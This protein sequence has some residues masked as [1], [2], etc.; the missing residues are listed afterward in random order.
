MSPAEIVYR[1]RQGWRRW[2][3]RWKPVNAQLLVGTQ[4]TLPI[5]PGLLE[6]AKLTA[7]NE[8]LLVAMAL[9]P[10]Q[11][12][13]R[14]LGREWA[15]KTD[16][17][18]WHFDP[19]SEQVWPQA[20][21]CMDIDLRQNGDLGDPKYIW[22]LNRL[23][24]L[25]PIAVVAALNERLDLTK[26]CIEQVESWIDSNPAYLGVNWS[27]GIEL[28]LR[29]VS[30]SVVTSC[31]GLH[32]DTK[33]KSK[34]IECLALHGFWIERFLSRHSSANN[35]LVAEASGLFLLGCLLPDLEQA[36]RWRS[37][38]KQML[39]KESMLQIHPDGIGAE[40]SFTYSCF[41]LEW[42][43]LC[44]LVG[45]R[46]KQPLSAS[47]RDVIARGSGAFKYLMDGY[48][49]PPQVGD[50]DEGRVLYI[51]GESSEYVS[52]ILGYAASLLNDP[53]VA[54]PC[55]RVDFGSVF[56]PP[57]GKGPDFRSQF[58]EFPSGGYT[59]IRDE[60]RDR[61]VFMLF[62]HGP[63][64]Y[65][66]L[67][68]HGHADALSIWL[69]IDDQPVLVDAGTYTYGSSGQWREYFKS[70]PAHNTLS[71]NGESSSV[72]ASSFNWSQKA[73]V[74]M[75]R[76]RRDQAVFLE[77]EHNGYLRRFATVHRRQITYAA[78]TF[79]IA[80]T[81]M[82]CPSSLPVEVN[83]LFHPRLDV[84]VKNLEIEILDDDD[85]IM[86]ISGKGGLAPTLYRG[87]EAPTRGWYSNSVG[88]KCP[89]FQCCFEGSLAAG[90]VFETII[91]LHP[92]ELS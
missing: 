60:F 59:A 20:K 40:Q 29:V 27:A 61:K 77:A 84:R 65:L 48:C 13:F 6:G 46:V 32:F 80:D 86:T 36:D 28:A 23:Q 47:V 19:V 50:D 68:A 62:D 71:V 30:I 7:F 8:E 58:H 56:Y 2:Y 43:M 49:H 90:E 5:I 53:T 75:T 44:V 87:S 38:G 67:A 51:A 9:L 24:F 72:M 26:F 4:R 34:V 66:S 31:L 85:L 89:T 76:S 3:F 37:V 39:E 79:R 21:Y 55:A 14:T 18:R 78:G 74:K 91:T 82:H 64:G 15:L 83:W 1:A 41:S 33:Q 54:S 81:L 17:R 16:D 69:H 22:E 45:D 42:L 12:K 25:Q 63:L 11:N 10:L 70:T 92:R 73:E 52:T 88:V 35:H 57:I